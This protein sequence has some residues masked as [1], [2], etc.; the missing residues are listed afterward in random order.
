MQTLYLIRC[1]PAGKEANADQSR[2]VICDQNASNLES[3]ELQSSTQTAITANA[4][5]VTNT[6]HYC[7]S[8]NGYAQKQEPKEL[9][10]KPSMSYWS[11]ESDKV[12]IPIW[13]RLVLKCS[14]IVMFSASITLK[15]RT[16]FTGVLLTFKSYNVL[17]YEM[18]E[19]D[20]Y[21]GYMTIHQLTLCQYLIPE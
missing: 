20:D 11:Y 4:T 18:S 3:D 17:V 1:G 19:Q 15:I 10:K 16:W 8:P 21:S 14:D 5:K 2:P 12:D 7:I 13:I 6:G 9:W